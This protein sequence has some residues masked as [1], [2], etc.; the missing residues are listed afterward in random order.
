VDEVAHEKLA[1][2]EGFMD[3][4]RDASWSGMPLVALALCKAL[5]V[6][7]LLDTTTGQDIRGESR[8]VPDRGRRRRHPGEDTH[9]RGQSR[10]GSGAAVAVGQRLDQGLEGFQRAGLDC[11]PGSS[12]DER[13][14]RARGGIGDKVGPVLE[15]QDRLP[16]PASHDACR[17]LRSRG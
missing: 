4:M 14:S 7:M 3:K 9:R 10:S 12:R 2:L 11:A 15:T 5:R 6:R 13:G 17:T 16:R 1:A 8:R